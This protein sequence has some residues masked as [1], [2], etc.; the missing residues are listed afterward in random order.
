M[1]A[2]QREWADGAETT[3]ENASEISESL[4]GICVKPTMLHEAVRADDT[5]QEETQFNQLHLDPTMSGNIVENGRDGR[6]HVPL[7]T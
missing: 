2:D 5:S 7:E 3:G 1:R 4:N 6:S